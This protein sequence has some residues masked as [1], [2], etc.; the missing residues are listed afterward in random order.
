M[1]TIYFRGDGGA[2]TGLGHL[3]RLVALAEAARDRGA[4]TVFLVND[5]PAA[6]A[7]VAGRGFADARL[8]PAEDD[9]ELALLLATAGAGPL[10][11][12]LRGKPPAFYERL[13]G[14]G[15]LV[16]AIDDM[17]EP[18]VAQLV[19]NGDAAP[20]YANYAELW[21]PQRF[22]LGTAYVPLPP[23]FAAE[24]PPAGDAAR[25]RLLLT[26]GG[27]DADDFSRRALAALAP[28]PP[29]EIDLC[30]GP[31]YRRVADARR[32]SR[33]SR[34]R[35]T[36]HAPA[37][38]MLA[39]YRRARLALCAGGITQYELLSQCVPVI[40][41]PHVERERAECRAF[42]AAGAALTFEADELKVGGAAVGAA[43]ALWDDGRRR[44]AMAAA[45][46]RLVD[47]RGAS[48]IL[49]E[50]AAWAARR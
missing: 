47:G 44:E 49:D 41:L 40:S 24:P 21:P 11:T 20:A 9:A 13:R 7:F 46:R 14:A 1:D 3:A 8:V 34:H 17:G 42:A 30:L 19:V 39:L 36:V 48:R 50:L 6:R 28:S 15:V 4:R 22:L 25:T 45:G 35:V 43:D 31:A 23:A 32:E 16:C 12:D 33:K 38:D 18:L 2:E 37:R 26:F 10:V 29:R 27:A 5:E